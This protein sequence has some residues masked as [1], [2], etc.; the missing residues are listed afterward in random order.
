LSPY[1]IVLADDHK[2]F[3]EALKKVI[4]DIED[5]NIIGEASDGLELLNLLKTTRPQMVILD[6]SMPRLRGL[7]ATREIKRLYPRVSILLLTMH[8]NREF[9][10][11]GLESGADGF[12]LKEGAIS[13]LVQAI[14][15]IREGK[16]F[17]SSLVSSELSDMAL[18]KRPEES[19]T[20]REKQI[21][22][23]L[24]EGKN[25]KQIADLLY[26]SPYTVRRHRQNIRHKLNLKSLV[27]LV[28]FAI[29]EGYTTSKS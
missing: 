25:H 23:L 11:Q 28:K 26:I 22:R 8:K 12:L 20:N 21:L 18:R 2:M 9:I 7:E 13:E 6:I 15:A 17:V 5:L 3:R 10:H 24:A 14:E 4:S 29:N 16:K 1:A 19:L 27:E